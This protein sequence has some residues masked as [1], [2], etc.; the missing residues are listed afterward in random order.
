MSAIVKPILENQADRK[1]GMPDYE[2][3]EQSPPSRECEYYDERDSN[4]YSNLYSTVQRKFALYS[5]R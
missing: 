3:V 1:A 5:R 2:N 4:L